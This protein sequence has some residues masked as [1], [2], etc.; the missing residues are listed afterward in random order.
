MD[1]Y[2]DYSQVISLAHP[3]IEAVAGPEDS[4]EIA[5]V[6]NDAM[7]ELVVKYPDRFPAA[8]ASLPLNNIEASLNEI[9]RAIGDLDCRGIQLFTNVMGKPLDSPEFMPIFEKMA[10]YDLPIWLHPARTPAIADYATEDRSMY[11]VYFS[12]G[13]PYETG[14]AMTRIIFT[15]IF[16]RHPNLKIITHHLGGVVPFFEDRI[17]GTYDQYLN[18]R[19]PGDDE[20]PLDKLQRPPLDYFRMFYAD[21]A[22]YG[23]IPAIECGLAFFGAD[24]VL[25]GSDYPFDVEGGAKYI[26]E[27]IRSVDGATASPGDKRKICEENARRLLKLD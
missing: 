6:A 8:V 21:T 24:H 23:T 22:V 18:R 10:G 1:A 5:R 17:C 4:P 19:Q 16:D 14:A 3:E 7:A 9:D 20:D 11:Q 12:F 13:W 2:D 27:T 26:R 25:F 15:G